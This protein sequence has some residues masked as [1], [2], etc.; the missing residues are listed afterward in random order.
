MERMSL[1]TYVI[2][3]HGRSD[4]AVIPPKRMVELQ[5]EIAQERSVIMDG[6]DM[7]QKYYQ[8]LIK[9]FYSFG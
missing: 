3:R 7:E 8:M 4:V 2:Q 1:K 9:I 6:R 5:R